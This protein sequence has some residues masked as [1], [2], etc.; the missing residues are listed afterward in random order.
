MLGLT[1]QKRRESALTDNTHR[2][3][4]LNYFAVLVRLNENDFVPCILFLSLTS[5]T[6]CSVCALNCKDNNGTSSK[7]GLFTLVHVANSSKK[8]KFAA[9]S[10]ISSKCLLL[11]FII[12][13][14]Q[15]RNTETRIS[16]PQR[17]RRFFDHEIVV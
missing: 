1:N 9:L 14:A 4:G 7:I 10:K 2:N 11:R 5:R 6:D 17:I 15:K 8:N 3:R 16:L 13:H 12:S